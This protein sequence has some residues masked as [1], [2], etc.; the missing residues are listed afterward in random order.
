MRLLIAFA[1]LILLGCGKS[2]TTPGLGEV[3][4]LSEEARTNSEKRQA[5]QDGLLASLKENPQPI[6]DAALNNV[7]KSLPQQIGDK[8]ASESLVTVDQKSL[9]TF[10]PEKW[11]VRGHF[12]G[13]VNGKQR[14]SIWQA[15]IQASGGKLIPGYLQLDVHD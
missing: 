4:K 13:Q 12:S 2:E 6:F 8:E 15:E 1:F 10:G 7:K 14:E 5:L 9:K 3:K 11:T